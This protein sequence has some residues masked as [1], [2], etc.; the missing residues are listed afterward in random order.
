MNKSAILTKAHKTAR[1]LMF[2]GSVSSYRAALS[3]GLKRA[4]AAAKSEAAKPAPSAHPRRIYL[5][6]PYSQ[7]DKAKKAGAKWDATARSW[8]VIAT[9]VPFSLTP[10]ADD[11]HNARTLSTTCAAY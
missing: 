8:Y 3:E 9:E 10:W 11:L 1:N 7:K 6:V 2:I 4:W 5:N